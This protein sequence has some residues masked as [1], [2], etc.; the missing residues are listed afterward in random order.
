MTG[1]PPLVDRNEVRRRLLEIFPEGTPNR[2]DV[3]SPIAAATVFVA[4]YIGA[5]ENGE[6]LLSP[7]PVYRMTE[8]QSALTDD[9][10]RREYARIMRKPGGAIEGRRWYADNTRESI[11]DNTL[12]EGLVVLGAVI[13]RAD[14]VVTANKP[15]YALSSSFAALFDP[16]LTGE[17]LETAIG[18]WRASTQTAGALARIA[19]TRQGATTSADWVLITF[20]SGET[21]KLRPGPS[22]FITKMV[23]EAFAPRFLRDPTVIAVSDS[24][25]KVFELDHSRAKAIGLNI[26]ADQNLPDIILVDLAPA[27]PLLVF[28]EVVAT[29]GPVSERRKAALEALVLE[30]GFPL[31]H[32]AFV[33]AYKDRSSQAFRR[34]VSSLAWGSYAWFA[35][36]PERLIEMAAS[37]TSIS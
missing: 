22:A 12:R 23:I 1:L 28:I 13:H 18:A 15:R 30:A 36:E 10:S 32:V 34:N 6:A 31:E 8:E 24:G 19:L 29:D 7:K 2:T 11:R 17:A 16:D 25:E 26:R 9:A 27:E 21:R 33:T 37:R 4:L 35:S 3:T 14:V 5:V 20:P